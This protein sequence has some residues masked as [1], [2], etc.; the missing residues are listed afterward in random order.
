[1]RWNRLF[2]C[3][4]GQ[5]FDEVA[6]PHVIFITENDKYDAGLPVYHINRT[7]EE[8]NHRSFPDESRDRPSVIKINS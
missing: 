1:M 6:E 7:I 4:K 2:P 3:E 5:E 8:F